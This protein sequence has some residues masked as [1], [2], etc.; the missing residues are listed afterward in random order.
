MTTYMAQ[1]DLRGP[2]VL[3]TIINRDNA[4]TPVFEGRG[5]SVHDAI[6]HALQPQRVSFKSETDELDACVAAMRS[7]SLIFSV[8][9]DGSMVSNGFR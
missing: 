1:F 3:V 6:V 7:K 2:S 9:N 4:R 8:Q 5:S